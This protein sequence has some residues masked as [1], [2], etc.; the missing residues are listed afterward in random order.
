MGKIVT[1]RVIDSDLCLKIG[2]FIVCLVYSVAIVKERH[3]IT[4]AGTLRTVQLNVNNSIGPTNT[5][6]TA[7]VSQFKDA[8]AWKC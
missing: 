3:F 6:M 1:D 5:R 4:A 8:G 2:H 7:N